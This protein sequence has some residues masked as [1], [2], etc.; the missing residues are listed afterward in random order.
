MYNKLTLYRNVIHDI[1]VLAWW[2]YARS[3][4]R[5]LKQVQA[6]VA[7]LLGT[8]PRG[9]QHNL[10]GQNC[11]LCD[12]HLTDSC[13]HIM[14]GC[15]EMDM[16]RAYWLSVIRF[17][18]PRV[19]QHEFQSMSVQEK[20][21]FLLSGLNNC[22]VSEWDALYRAIAQFVWDKYMCRDEKYKMI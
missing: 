22:Y 14:F 2:S 17:L 13:L 8:Q 3:H 6:T 4:P 21:T 9:M 11:I 19:M 15:C 1:Q 12:D 20:L 10:N 18:M 16:T 5:K 7:L